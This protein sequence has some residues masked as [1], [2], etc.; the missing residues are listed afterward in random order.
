MF[1]KSL[2]A[3]NRPFLEAAIVL[4]QAGQ[5]PANSYLLDLD[6]MLANA[7]IMS[8]EARRLGLAVFAMTKQFGRNPPALDA[9]KEGGIDRFVAVDMA[10]ARPIR[11]HDHQLAHIGHLSQ[12]PRAEAPRA[13]AM[14]PEFWTVFTAKK[15]AEAAEA[16]AAEGY[17]QA[18][19]AR[20]FAPQDT[21]YPGHEGGFAVAEIETAIESLNRRPGG[22][23][24]GLTTF[25]ALLF[26][27]TKGAVQPTPNLATLEATADRLAR[28]NVQGVEINAPGT[29]STQVLQL[30]A[31]GGATQVEPGHGLTGSTPLHAVAE[32]PERP[33]M[34]YLT[35][36]SHLYQ[37]RAYC[38]G[39]GLYID[40]VFAPYPLKA[41]VGHD[42]DGALARPIDAGIPEPAMI[43]YY[44][45]L[46]RGGADQLEVGD[47]VIFGF[48][49]QAFVTRAFIVPVAGIASGRPEVRGIWTADGRRTDWP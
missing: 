35:E 49:A 22:R 34:L 18:L 2:L 1:L 20:I 27:E 47:T 24:A 38:F 10:C 44:G 3:K 17:Q 43:D 45:Q 26:D 13:A 4:H 21:F 23:F 33:A 8:D 48:R 7:R 16:A 32:L 37:G 42:P 29:T 41:F 30:L 15:A 12:I 40:P 11:D 39:G 46:H 19:L 5:V 28:L 25:P 36:V 14:R 31:D 9:L 6:T